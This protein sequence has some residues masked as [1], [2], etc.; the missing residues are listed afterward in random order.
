VLRSSVDFSSDAVI[1][2][3]DLTGKTVWSGKAGLKGKTA[4]LSL[5]SL[6]NGLYILNLADKGRVSQSRISIMH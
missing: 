5:S 1:S 4:S 2:V 6:E 3:Q